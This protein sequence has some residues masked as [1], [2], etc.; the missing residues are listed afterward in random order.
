MYLLRRILNPM[1][2]MDAIDFLLD[3]LRDITSNAEFLE[4][5]NTWWIDSIKLIGSVG[6]DHDTIA[7]FRLRFSGRSWRE[8][9]AS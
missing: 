3:K 5:M 1:D 8:R 9:W 4:W 6:P 2:T 7:A